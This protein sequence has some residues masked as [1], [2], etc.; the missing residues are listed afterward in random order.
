MYAGHVAIGLAIKARA[1][2]VPTTAVIWGVVLLDLLNGLFVL[3]GLDQVVPDLTAGPYL[4]F[5]LRFIDWDHSLLM[6]VVWSAAWALLFV[7]VSRGA[8]EVAALAVFSHFLADG[9]MHNGDLALYPF[10]GAHLGLGLWGR[11]GPW[12]WVLEGVFCAA[13]CAYAWR[14]QALRGVNWTLPCAVVAAMFFSLS[15]WFSPMELL[16]VHLPEDLAGRLAGGMV[17]AGF[18]LPG[19]LLLKWIGHA[20]QRAAVPP[21]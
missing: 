9:L 8:A 16:A 14:A 7:K 21:T 1:P 13:L 20:E 18:L 6:A 4:Y 11:W 10:A 5:D 19:W 12:S 17:A 15:P 2:E 3:V